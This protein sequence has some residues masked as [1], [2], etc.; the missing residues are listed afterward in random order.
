M[1]IVVKDPKSDIK[2]AGTL[3]S[4]QRKQ[5][6][7]P[8]GER[9]LKPQTAADLAQYSVEFIQ[10][11]SA[12]NAAK[13]IRAE[14]IKKAVAALEWLKLHNTCYLNIIND[15]VR[16]KTYP[17]ACRLLFLMD[18][19]SDVLPSMTTRS[20]IL[21]VSRS[22][23]SGNA[24]LIQWEL[25]PPKDFTAV[26]NEDLYNVYQGKLTEVNTVND[27]FVEAVKTLIKKRAICRKLCRTIRKELDF[28]YNDL[29]ISKKRD[30]MRAW[31]VEFEAE[32]EISKINI[33]AL[34][35]D[36]SGITEGAEIRIGIFKT[37]ATKR[38]PT[39]AKKGAKGKTDAHGC[40][41]LETTQK[42]KLFLVGKL[43]GCEEIIYP[44]KITPGKD[45]SVTLH[46]VKLPPKE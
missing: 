7:T 40:L 8:V 28:H 9:F 46:F 23:L 41:I 6:S 14:K 45:L 13:S 10:Y 39:F 37:K 22:I 4:E 21:N 44:I 26:E 20:D 2:I 29:P 18:K 30:A 24:A 31:G 33:L 12:R 43:A 25:V 34:F 1:A 36:E 3:K 17:A 38:K 15:K 5:L 32:K 27:E 16:Y 35:A 11:I 19:D 42:G